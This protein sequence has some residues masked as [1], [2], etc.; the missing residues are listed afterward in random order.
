MTLLDELQNCQDQASAKNKELRTCLNNLCA[1]ITPKIV[2]KTIMH[3]T[4]AWRKDLSKGKVIRM[5]V[6]RGT[7][8][9]VYHPW[10]EHCGFKYTSRFQ[11]A[12]ANIVEI[13]ESEE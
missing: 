9:V 12:I 10:Y 5:K 4:G 8:Y 2:A 7:L 1:G 6:D 11:T 3:R 13:K